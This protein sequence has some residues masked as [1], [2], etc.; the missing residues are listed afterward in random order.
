VLKTARARY[1]KIVDRAPRAFDCQC[2]EGGEELEN[3]LST[4]RL[5]A[6]G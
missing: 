2:V 3:V 5:E 1:V 6:G 4:M